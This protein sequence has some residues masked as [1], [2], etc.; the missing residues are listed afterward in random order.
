MMQIR[1]LTWM[2]CMIQVDM[3]SLLVVLLFY[4]GHVNRQF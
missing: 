3:F 1:S 4:G 2:S